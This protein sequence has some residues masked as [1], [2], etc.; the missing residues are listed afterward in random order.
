MFPILAT[1]FDSRAK[2]DERS[3]RSLVD[4][5]I[6]AGVHGI[7][8]LGVLGEVLRLSDAERTEVT[9]IVIDE[10][11]GRVPVISGTGASGTDLAVLYSK[12][13]ESLGADAVMVA[14]PRLAKQNDDAIVKYYEDV[15]KE[16][17][18][19]I[20][21]QD[22]PVTYSVQMSPKLIARL[23][24]IEKVG[25]L[26]LED[27][28]TLIKMSQILTLTG[29][30][31]GIFGALG[32]LYAFEE[33]SRGAIGIMTGFAYPEIFVHIFNAFSREDRDV[34][35]DLFYRALP[36]IRYE[37]QPSISV[38]ARKE[39]LKKRGIINNST[40][41]EPASKLDSQSLKEIDE[42]LIAIRMDEILASSKLTAKASVKS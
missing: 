2:L 14:P 29:D 1:P 21:V 16:I 34:A 32:G 6:G 23:S 12:E 24:E 5:E 27:P 3:V 35:R 26:K 18:I 33:L 31:L 8:I 10:V 22:E 4:F 39:I 40:A 13:A 41:R 19:P 17:S 7:T 9:R 11:R 38:S 42:M 25:Y 30:R 20:V 28:P 15:A 36:L 37:A